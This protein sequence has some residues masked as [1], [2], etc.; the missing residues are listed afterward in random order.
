[1]EDEFLQGETNEIYCHCTECLKPIEILSLDN[2]IIKF[3]CTDEKN[4][5]ENEITFNEYIKKIKLN[6]NYDINILC[7]NHHKEYKYF[8]VDCNKHICKI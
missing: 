4:K 3:Q 7:L 5:H 1:M 8:C 6:K 2:N